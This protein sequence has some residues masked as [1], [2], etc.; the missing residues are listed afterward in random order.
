MFFYKK[1]GQERFPKATDHTERQEVWAVGQATLGH[2]S[3]PLLYSTEPGFPPD[4]V[5]PRPHSTH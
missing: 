5:A 3:K 4:N 1:Q 2:A